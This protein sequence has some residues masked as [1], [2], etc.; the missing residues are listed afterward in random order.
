MFK[1]KKLFFFLNLIVAA[2]F[3]NAQATN[4]DS[5]QFIIKSNPPNAEK[6]KAYK[7]LSQAMISKDFDECQAASVAGA[8]LAEKLKDFASLAEF[9]KLTG[10]SW[11]FKGSYDSAAVY[12]Y[13]AMDILKKTDAP[14]AK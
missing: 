7:A 12:Y 10:L 2:L 4:T 5:L 13:I 6:V 11:Y 9:K 1:Y 14:S 3:A 8:A